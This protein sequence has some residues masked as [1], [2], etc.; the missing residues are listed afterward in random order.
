MVDTKENGISL[1]N[2]LVVKEFSN[3]FPDELPG[4]P[5]IGKWC[6]GSI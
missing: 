5:L 3:V 1:E 6:L 2:I 4:I